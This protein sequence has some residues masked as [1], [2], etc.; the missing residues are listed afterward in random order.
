MDYHPSELDPSVPRMTPELLEDTLGRNP[1]IAQEPTERQLAFLEL[2]CRDALYGGAAAG[3]KMLRLDEPV[4]TPTGWATIGSLA[5]G[6]WILDENGIPCRVTGL[7]N[8]D[9]SPECYRL[10]FDDGSEVEACADHQWK[11]FDARELGQL[12]KL[13]PEWRA[14]R[15]AKRP[16]RSKI[17][18]GQ[19]W[20]HTPEHREFLSRMTSERNRRTACAKV[21]PPTGTVRTTREIA[22]TLRT[23]RGSTNH[24]IPVA[25]PL[26][27]PDA[28]LRLD[29]YLLGVWLG[30]GTSS[31]GAVTSADPEI[32]QAFHDAGFTEGS[33]WAKAGNKAWTQSFHGLRPILRTLGVFEN[34]HI[35]RAYLRASREQRLALLQGLMD[36]DGTACASGAVEFTNTNREL[37]EGVFELVVSLGWKAR[38][39]ESRAKLHGED[40]GPKW[41]IK[42][43][44]SERVF[45]LERKRKR[46]KT[47]ARR[48]TR[49]RYIVGCV[50]C[51]PTPMRCIS[52]DSPNRLFLVGRNMIPTHNSSALLMAALQ[53]CHCVPGYAALI[54]RRHFADLKLP[55]GLI[56]RS[57]EWLKDKAKWNPQEHRWRFKGGATLQF[58]YAD[59][60][61][62]E[63]RYHGAEFQGIFLDE[64]VQFSERQIKFFFERLRRREGINAPLRVRLGTTPGGIGH[65]FLK[66]RYINPGTPGK[67]FITAKLADN[68]HVNREEYVESLQEVDPLRRKQMLDGDWDAVAGGRFR[69]EWLANAWKVERDACVLERWGAESH[70]FEEV[71]RFAWQS[72]ATFQTCDPAASTSAAADYFVL[73]TWKLSPKANLVWWD[74]E[75]RKLEIDEQ[76]LC[77]KA[78]YR[79]HRPQFVAVE[80]VLNQRALA[81]LLRKSVNPPMVVRGVSPLG[82]DKLARAVGF[83]NLAATGRLFLPLGHPTFPLDEVKGELVRFTGTDADGHDDVCDTGSYAAELLPTIRP[84]GPGSGR[85]PFRHAGGAGVRDGRGNVSVKVRRARG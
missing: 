51:E 68:E 39:V 85:A 34:K 24:A 83:I 9:P 30:D 69:P 53:F 43:S 10:T 59:K 75:R 71:E 54:V 49:F 21:P 8:I 66:R 74:C 70:E 28:N 80:E 12:T 13:D 15:R 2:E 4:P 36:T 23:P 3:G 50:R 77:A 55:G 78:S 17:G 76:V 6:D 26:E 82:R 20:N 33:K 60:E 27:L 45:R 11:T 62:D 73:S 64:A 61:G 22:E 38:L 29:P 65:E 31:A 5:V 47:N 16:S 84:G 7:S 25:G 46:Q 37:A 57:L 58:G 18:A 35:P 72:A 42:W 14:R 32:F 19:R 79:R 81:Q 63:Q 1:Y 56:D 48:T 41:D 52:V 40:C 67:V 44:P